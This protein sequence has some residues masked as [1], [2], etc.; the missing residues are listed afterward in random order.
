[1]EPLFLA[2][3]VAVEVEAEAGVV[4]AVVMAA[5]E[6][7]AAAMAAAVAAIPLC[8]HHQALFCQWC[9]IFPSTVRRACGGTGL[10]ACG[11]QKDVL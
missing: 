5:E 3:A 2:A 7:V 11:H 6:V 8:G 10:K 1:M 9:T 4:M